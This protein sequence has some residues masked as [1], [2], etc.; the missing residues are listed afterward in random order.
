M[1]DAAYKRR[2][3]NDQS[4]DASWLVMRRSPRNR[5]LAR[6]HAAFDGS[7]ELVKKI[8]GRRVGE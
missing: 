6:S 1:G 5:L 7:V 2:F 4:S 8:I 3:G